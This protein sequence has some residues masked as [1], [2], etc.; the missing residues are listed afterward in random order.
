MADIRRFE[1]EDWYG[2]AGAEV[3]K[4]KTS[5]F[6]S[7]I[8][9]NDGAVDVMVVADANGLEID[10]YSSNGE[11]VLTWRKERQLSSIQAEGELNHLVPYLDRYS[12]APDLT[13]AL[14][15]PDD[16]IIEGFEFLGEF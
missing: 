7:N 1:K 14:D 8:K 3:F 9:M 13:Y 5:P 4:D 10:V 12:Y 11:S 15:H 6:I 2:Y 16:D